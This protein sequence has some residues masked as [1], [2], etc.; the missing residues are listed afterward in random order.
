MTFSDRTILNCTITASPLDSHC[1]KNSQDLGGELSTLEHM[2][3]LDFRAN[4]VDDR[5]QPVLTGR[6]QNF[7]TSIDNRSEIEKVCSRIL[8]GP[9]VYV[10]LKKLI[11][12]ATAPFFQRDLYTDCEQPIVV[13]R[14]F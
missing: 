7:G 1:L 11:Q 9:I 10:H 6:F 3:A 5:A 2:V 13:R 8:W 14:I 4:R 12:Q